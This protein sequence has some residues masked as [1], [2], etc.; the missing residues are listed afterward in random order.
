M[1]ASLKSAVPFSQVHTIVEDRASYLLPDQI[2]RYADLR[3]SQEGYLTGPGVPELTLN[4]WSKRQLASLLGVRWDRWFSADAVS[5]AERAEETNRRLS[6]LPGETK[7]RSMRERA[8][9]TGHVLRALLSPSFTP[10]DDARIFRQMVQTFGSGLDRF[11]FTRI[12]ATDVTTIYAAVD[13]EARVVGEDVLHPGFALRNS[14]VGASALSLD[15]YWLRLACQ[16]G[17]LVS[18]GSKRLLYR[19]HRKCEDDQLVASIAVAMKN[20]PGRWMFALS[21]MEQAKASPVP[22]PDAAIESVLESASFPRELVREAQTTALKDADFTRYGVVQAITFVAHARNS[23]S[24]LR[25]A[26]ERAAGDY[27]AATP[28]P[29]NDGV[30]VLQ[31]QVP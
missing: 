21:L 19:T 23:D 20:L 2:V 28:V 7:L 22:H 11:A 3:L 15:D 12:D 31:E 18:V 29:A 17:L 8:A 26:L 25:F 10:I 27:L 6:R 4:S 9:P 13:R 30:I 5:G 24:E 14:E 1:H 16:N